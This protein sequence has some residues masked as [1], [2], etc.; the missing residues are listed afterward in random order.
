MFGLD[1]D[2]SCNYS[3]TDKFNI[4]TGINYINRKF[5][6]SYS[7]RMNNQSAF[8]SNSKYILNYLSIP[9]KLSY[10]IFKIN[11]VTISPYIGCGLD[12]LFKTVYY[13]T[14]ITPKIKT[15]S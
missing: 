13:E 14:I 11:K 10:S 12:Y 1:F 3:I 15:V 4:G 9:I 5:K 7:I 6:Y 2:I 8:F